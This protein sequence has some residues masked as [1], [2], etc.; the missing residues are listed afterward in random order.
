MTETPIDG[1]TKLPSNH[2]VEDTVAKITEL[3]AAKPVTIFAVV[4]H[5]GEAAKVGL[6]MFP[7]KLI[8]FGNAKAGTPL[9][10]AA[11]SLAIDLPLKLLVWQ[12]DQQQT[13]VGYNS[14][15]YLRERHHFPEE[16]AANLALA[17][18]IARQAAS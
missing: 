12:D 2:S 14:V 10:T 17:E 4:D 13:W 7:T 18:A 11:P 16:L 6:T 8:I 15:A 9:M 5:S 3:L 1:F